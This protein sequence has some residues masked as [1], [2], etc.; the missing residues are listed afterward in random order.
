MKQSTF[1]RWLAAA[2]AANCGGHA[3]PHCL[4]PPPSHTRC[5][6]TRKTVV[7]ILG[8]ASVVDS[9][10][11]RGWYPV[12]I[13]LRSANRKLA[14]TYA[15]DH[16]DKDGNYRPRP[17]PKAPFCCSTYVSIGATCPESCEFKR[18]SDGTPGACFAD[19]GFTRRLIMRLDKA[20]KRFTS[21]QVGLIEAKA[22]SMLF[23]N[24]VP[25]DGARGGRDNRLHV[26]GEVANVRHAQ[27]LAA[28]EEGYRGHGGGTT[29]TYTHRWRQIARHHFGSIAVWA[30]VE[31]PAD[32]KKAVSRG[33]PVAVT[34]EKFP[35]GDKPF[36]FGGSKVV[37]CVYETRGVT[38]VKCRLCLEPPKPFRTGE[39]AIGFQLHGGGANRVRFRLRKLQEAA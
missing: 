36:M 4:L 20:A 8:I 1:R 25:Q 23:S 31:K 15:E 27:A 6:I 37:P 30:S 11:R 17:K 9:S 16:W 39:R 3:C 7:P 24:G 10:S 29:W 19:T 32:V 26:G 34:V 14:P 21:E 18:E 13:R 38:C 2:P 28:A 35:N 12:A 5:C 22:V 33:Y